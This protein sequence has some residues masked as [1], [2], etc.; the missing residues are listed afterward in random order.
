MV[1]TTVVLMPDCIEL[2][3]D[4]FHRLPVL[5]ALVCDL[6]DHVTNHAT[7]TDFDVSDASFEKINVNVNVPC[8]MSAS[9]IFEYASY[10]DATDFVLSSN[11]VKAAIARR[12]LDWCGVDV[13]TLYTHREL[14]EE[15]HLE[16]QKV[17]QHEQALLKAAHIDCIEFKDDLG[18]SFVALDFDLCLPHGGLR[19]TMDDI[20]DRWNQAQDGFTR[21]DLLSLISK[22]DEYNILLGITKGKRVFIGHSGVTDDGYLQS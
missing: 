4:Q 11:P 8:D 21:H 2:S 6:S 3:K 7:A 14:R 17:Q 1:V 12:T 15:L 13:S 9:D 5:F 18:S 16:K 10:E 20:I 19:H 22:T